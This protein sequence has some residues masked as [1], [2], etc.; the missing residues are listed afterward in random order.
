LPRSQR[1]VRRK[2]GKKAKKKIQ[3]VQK[4]KKIPLKEKLSTTKKDV[5]ENFEGKKNANAP[6]VR[7]CRQGRKPSAEAGAENNGSSG[8]SNSA[9]PILRREKKGKGKNWEGEPAEKEGLKRPWGT[10]VKKKAAGRGKEGC[11]ELAPLVGR[12]GLP[13]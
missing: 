2:K 13:E 6:E 5:L 1:A 11:R 9:D 4:R 3:F 12:R 8:N 7:R 10:H